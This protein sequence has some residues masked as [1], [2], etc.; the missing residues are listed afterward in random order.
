MAGRGSEISPGDTRH[1]VA[2]NRAPIKNKTHK[3]HESI[4]APSTF[5]VGDQIYYLNK[6]ET[7]NFQGNNYYA[8]TACIPYHI[9]QHDVSIMDKALIDCVLSCLQLEAYGMDIH[10]RPS[11]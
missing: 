10:D 9:S 3:A 1:V 11:T 8:H 5:Q 6:G 4:S 2:S 7:V